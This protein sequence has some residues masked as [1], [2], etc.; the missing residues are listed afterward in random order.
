MLDA[1]A[2]RGTRFRDCDTAAPITLV[3]HASVLTGLYP[4]RHGIRDNITFSLAGKIGTVPERLAAAGYDTA[5]VVSAIVLA[6]RHGLDRGFRRYDDDLGAGYAAGN[7][8]AERPADRTTAAALAVAA[9][10]KPPYFLWVHYYDPHKDYTPP[11][12]FTGLSGPSRLYDGEIAF[13]DE[14]IGEL[15]GKLP[16]NTNIVVVGDPA[17]CSA[18]T[19]RRPTASSSSTARGGCR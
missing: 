6:R 11:S 9:G 12:R 16:A 8:V 5:A 13:M 2:A 19:A 15:L 1:L 10:L 18:S 4:P 17:R 7:L 3:S 14:Q